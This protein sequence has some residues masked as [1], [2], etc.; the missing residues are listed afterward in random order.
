FPQNPISLPNQP[1]IKLPT[2]EWNP[3]RDSSHE[4]TIHFPDPVDD[5]LVNKIYQDLKTFHYFSEPDNRGG[6]VTIKGTT[7][8]FR[9]PFYPA[10]L[11]ELQFIGSLF[12]YNQLTDLTFYNKVAL[13]FDDAEQEVDGQT[14]P[15]HLLDGQRH[16]HAERSSVDPCAVKFKTWAHER[17]INSIDEGNRKLIN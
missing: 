1:T 3:W 15:G 17:S 4:M 13:T 8:Y 5:A 10:P 2:I 12:P 16:W 11:G 6:R 9:A 7:A 14:L